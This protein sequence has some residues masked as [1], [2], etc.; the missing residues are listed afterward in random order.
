MVYGVTNMAWIR[1]RLCKLQKKGSLDS[2]LQVIKFTSCSPMVIGPL[3]VPSFREEDFKVIFFINIIMQNRHK[4]YYER[5]KT[6]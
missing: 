6:T 1:A 3:R 4:S 2:Q 5:I